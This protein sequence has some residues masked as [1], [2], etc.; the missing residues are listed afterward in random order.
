MQKQSIKGKQS[1]RYIKIYLECGRSFFNYKD[2]IV[3]S[4]PNKLNIVD[5]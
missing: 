4:N 2:Q 3:L 1:D 5:K